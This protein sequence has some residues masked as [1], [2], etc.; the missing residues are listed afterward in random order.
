MNEHILKIDQKT[1]EC[2]KQALHALKK[3]HGSRFSKVFK[4]I[5][6]DNSSEFSEL[7]QTLDLDQ[8]HPYTS[9]ERGRMSVTTD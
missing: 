3:S 8:A 2:V 1:V 7:S 6:A 9:S 5:T 4:T